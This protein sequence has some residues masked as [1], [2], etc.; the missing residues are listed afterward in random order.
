MREA[1]DIVAG[2]VSVKRYV[3]FDDLVSDLD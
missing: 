3:S 2:R 1:D